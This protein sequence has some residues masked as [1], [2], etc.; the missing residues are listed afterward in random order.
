MTAI[1]S[2]ATIFSTTPAAFSSSFSALEELPIST[3]PAVTASTPAEEPVNSAVTVTSGYFAIKLSATAFASFSIDVLP[4]METV[5]LMAA[6]S[7]SFVSSAFV[8]SAFVSSVLVS[9]AVLSV[10]CAAS[11]FPVSLEPHAINPAVIVTAHTS[12]RIFLL[13][14]IFHFSSY[15]KCFDRS[16][17][18]FP[19]SSLCSC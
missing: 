6:P 9:A 10:V 8:S 17:N 18:V 15:L 5:P 12:A 1:P 16:A 19:S 4:A 11:V 13:L 2:I 14:I 3:L 7:A